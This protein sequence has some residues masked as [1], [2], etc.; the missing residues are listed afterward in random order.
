MTVILSTIGFELEKIG[1]QLDQGKSIREVID[2]LVDE[3]AAI[4]FE[5]DGYSENWV[6]EAKKRG[7]YVNTRFTENLENIIN[8]GKVLVDSGVYKES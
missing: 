6:K 3:T 1:A 5:G 2:G 4:R 8:D 7:L